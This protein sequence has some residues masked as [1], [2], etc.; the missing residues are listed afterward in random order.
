MSEMRGWHVNGGPLDNG[1][2][3]WALDFE[4][5]LL[6][7]RRVGAQPRPHSLQPRGLAL[8]LRDLARIES[9]QRGELLVGERQR[10]AQLL[11][12]LL[13]LRFRST[14]CNELLVQV[15]VRLLTSLVEFLAFTKRLAQLLLHLLRPFACLS[16]CRELLAQRGCGTLGQLQTRLKLSGRVPPARRRSISAAPPQS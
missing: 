4:Q 5:R 2:L 14:A 8:E 7:R 11:L 15:T 6:N 16:A 3:T 12:Q 9:A 13:T 10:C 1:G